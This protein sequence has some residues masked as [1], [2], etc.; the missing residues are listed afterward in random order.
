MSNQL[1]QDSDYAYIRAEHEKAMPDTVNIL[2]L[3]QTADGTGG[4]TEKYVT[5]YENVIA[6]IGEMTG[7]DRQAA[8]RLS[9]QADA[10]LT[11]PQDQ[12]IDERNR[13]QVLKDARIFEVAFVGNGRS[14]DTA[15]RVFL[16]RIA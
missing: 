4:Q 11:L 3:S 12:E 1:L 15:R 7:R 5:A 2:K 10:I 16:R 8:E 6:R 13:V 9:I 14:Y